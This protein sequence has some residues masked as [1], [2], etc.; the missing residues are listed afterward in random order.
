MLGLPSCREIAEQLSENLDQPLTGW[1]AIKMKI[2]LMMCAYCQRYGR[3]MELTSQTIRS[4]DEAHHPDPQLEESVV[5]I[6]RAHLGQAEK[7]D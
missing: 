6:Y 7:K 2:H 4:I 3:Q 1:R 5:Q